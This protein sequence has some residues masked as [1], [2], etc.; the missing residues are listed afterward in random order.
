MRE[1]T[2][3]YTDTKAKF[4]NIEGQNVAMEGENEALKGAITTLQTNIRETY[5]I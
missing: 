2:Q 5:S 4:K 3:E 1:F